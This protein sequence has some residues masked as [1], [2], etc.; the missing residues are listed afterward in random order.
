M[1]GDEPYIGMSLLVGFNY[2]PEGWVL[3]DGSVLPIAQYDVLF[4]LIGTTYGGDGVNNFAVPDLRGRVPMNQGQGVPI[5]QSGGAES[6]TLVASQYPAH[7]HTLS[8]SGQ[9]QN[10]AVPQGAVLASGVA[11][12]TTTAPNGQ[13]A[14]A[15]LSMA[16]TPGPHENRQPYLAL[17]WIIATQ[18]IYPSRS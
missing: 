4:S 17:N 10:I 1:G 2:A 9:T 16:G 5:G 6:V 8:A 11:D 3:C 13:V 12:Y 7:T 15:T 14:P 18:G